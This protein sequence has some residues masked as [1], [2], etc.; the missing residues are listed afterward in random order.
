MH[1]RKYMS[2][3][4]SV[5]IFFQS[6][7]PIIAMD[8]VEKDP[9]DSSSMSDFSLKASKVG[10]SSVGLPSKRLIS[11]IQELEKNL[12]FLD[13]YKSTLAP[14]T[15]WSEP[16]K[17]AAG[18]L[19]FAEHNG[20][21][22][23]FL[24]ER[25]DEKGSWCNLGGG[26][27]T[28]EDDLEDQ[29]ESSSKKTSDI[30]HSALDGSLSQKRATTLDDDGAR[31]SEEESNGIYTLHRRLLKKCPFIDTYDLNKKIYYRMYWQRVEHINPEIFLNKLQDSEHDH[32][33]EYTDF[34]WFKAEDLLTALLEPEHLL[35]QNIYGPL[36]NMLS[37]DSAIAFIKELSTSKKLNRYKR[38]IRPLCNRLYIIGNTATDHDT[39]PVNWSLLNVDGQHE[40]LDDQERGKRNYLSSEQE[41]KQLRSDFTQLPTT[42]LSQALYQFTFQPNFHHV[43]P[44]SSLIEQDQFDEA[45]AAHGMAMV[46][47]KSYF[48]NHKF[49]L[50]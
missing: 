25:N 13:H 17:S 47:L 15:F 31:E 40:L 20:E 43:I 18:I 36:L 38:H 4:L 32:N 29:V 46:L 35:R 49:Y 33:K 22:Y 37:T 5:S 1:F 34:K 6:I 44:V 48:H 7:A 23:I 8:L 10:S 41:L 9:E 2:L 30:L 45:V 11:S 42:E 21:I 50:W 14:L 19:H 12:P 27:D 39:T 28:R 24:G 16:G 26:S 3:F